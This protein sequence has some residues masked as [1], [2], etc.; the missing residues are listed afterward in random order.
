MVKVDDVANRTAFAL[1]EGVDNG[2]AS[3]ASGSVGSFKLFPAAIE[4]QNILAFFKES[5]L[6]KFEA[7][8]VLM[9]CLVSVSAGQT[10]SVKFFESIEFAFDWF[11]PRKESF[12]RTSWRL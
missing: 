10:H 6:D 2:V 7:C 8:D 5:R 3:S 12:C 11:P 9:T 4:G 1:R